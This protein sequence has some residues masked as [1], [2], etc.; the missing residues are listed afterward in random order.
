MKRQILISIL[1]FLTLMIC[2]FALIAGLEASRAAPQIDMPPLTQAD[3]AHEAIRTSCA[4][5]SCSYYHTF[6]VPIPN[7]EVV[8][9]YLN[10]RWTCRRI[11]SVTDLGIFNIDKPYWQC[12]GLAFP[13]GNAT[14][15]ISPNELQA[16][17][18]R[19]IAY[20]WWE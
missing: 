15:R 2:P 19:L 9:Y 11:Q 16:Q 13:R 6:Q 12:Q 1:S 10:K 20:V 7:D 14:I 4:S 18:T 8:Q 3:T 5:S 17:E